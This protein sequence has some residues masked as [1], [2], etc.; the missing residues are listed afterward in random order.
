MVVSDS[1]DPHDR[2]KGALKAAY[3]YLDATFD[4]PGAAAEHCMAPI[5]VKETPMTRVD[6]APA[7]AL[8]GPIQPSLLRHRER[9]PE[10]QEQCPQPSSRSH[11]HTSS[12][13]ITASL[14]MVCC[15]RDSQCE[16]R[17]HRPRAEIC[18]LARVQCCLGAAASVLMTIADAQC[19]S[20][21]SSSLQLTLGARSRPHTRPSATAPSL[22]SVCV[23]PRP[24]TTRARSFLCA[25]G[26][27]IEVIVNGACAERVQEGWR[28]EG[29]TRT[30]ACPCCLSGSGRP[31]RAVN[32][33]LCAGLGV[34]GRGR[35]AANIRERLLVDAAWTPAA[36]PTGVQSPNFPGLWRIFVAPATLV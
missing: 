19:A 16:H 23:A 18:P 24:P 8:L 17:L 12:H 29:C 7:R 11:T 30:V 9:A 25:G 35:G 20:T 14:C 10:A 36:A 4:S 21:G 32:E 15:T 3:Q 1:G 28:C 27:R 13:V 2:G 34:G 26:A 31:Q 5:W 6:G 22:T 33:L